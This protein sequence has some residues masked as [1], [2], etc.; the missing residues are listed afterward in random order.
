MGTKSQELKDGCLARAAMDEPIFVLRAQDKS[1]PKLVRQWAENF[2]QHHVKAETKGHALA[3]A[4]TKHTGALE[5]ADAMEAWQ[6][7]KQAD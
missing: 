4:I 5:V 7:R 1:A 2:R 3:I 6:S